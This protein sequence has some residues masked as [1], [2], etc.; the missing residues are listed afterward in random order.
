MEV[1]AELPN[2]RF[3]RSRTGQEPSIQRQ[4][5]KG[6]KE[7]QALDEFT[8]KE[9]HRDHTF[10]LQFAEWYMNRPLIRTGGAEAIEGQIGAF[11][12][13]HAGVSNQQKRVTTQIVAAEDLLLQELILLGGERT[14]ESLG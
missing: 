11:A 2:E 9:V 1:I 12:D 7:T 3:F 6:T 10:R 14:R 4:R 8:N 13:A 5:I